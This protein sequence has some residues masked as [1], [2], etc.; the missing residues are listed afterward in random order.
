MKLP[1]RLLTLTAIGAVI[2]SI[3]GSVSASAQATLTDDQLQKISAN[4]LT[5]KSTLNQ[6][7]ATDALLRVNRGQ[8]YEAMV[9]KLME[10]FNGRLTNN[11]L[12]ARATTVVASSY[13]TAL[14]KFRDD[15]STYERLLVAAIAVDC[16]TKPAEFHAAVELA[17]D[18]RFTVHD[19][20]NSL[21][22]YIDDYRSAVSD[23]ML[24]YQRVTGSS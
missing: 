15:Y 10:R 21:H 11:D 8:M 20:V 5:I 23:F 17:R 12:D 18:A 24:N 9:S 6:L 4:C 7:K 3:L 14:Q 1:A 22:R 19:D 2:F 13:R 16:S